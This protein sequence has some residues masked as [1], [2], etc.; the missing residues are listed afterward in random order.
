MKSATRA[1]FS[2]RAQQTISL[3]RQSPLR[4]VCGWRGSTSGYFPM[5]SHPVM[6]L[7]HHPRGSGVTAFEDGREIVFQ[8]HG[9]VIYPARLRHDQRMSTPGA[10]ICLHVGAPMDWLAEVLYIPPDS[11]GTKRADR[12][13]RT[14][15]LH[16]AQVRPDPGRRVELDLR[17][18]ALVARLLQLSPLAAHENP[19]AT[20]E[21]HVDRARQFICENYARITSAGE[22]ARHV[23]VSE[24]YLRHVFIRHGGPGLN[25]LILRRGKVFVSPARR[26]RF[27]IWS[28]PGVC[29][30]ISSNKLSTRREI[31]G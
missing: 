16:L 27:L 5:H 23:G 9:T 29:P 15:F 4:F 3:L 21:T 8:P 7:V 2:G 24:D 26:G 11:S 20:P 13:V 12:F 31:A 1:P 14:E 17:I 28:P 22:V 18:T 19:P 25:R 10:D 6:E 30:R